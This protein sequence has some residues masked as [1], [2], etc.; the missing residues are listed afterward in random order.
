MKRGA[1]PLTKWLPG[2]RDVPPSL[3]AKG[4]LEP[5]QA[6][7][8]HGLLNLPIMSLFCSV[9]CPGSVIL[10]TYEAMQ[11]LKLQDR[12]IAGGFHSPME[13][14]CLDILLRGRTKLILCPARGL[15]RFRLRPEWKIPMSENRL[16]VLSPFDESVRRS[17]VHQ[18]SARNKFVAA[19]ADMTLIPFAARRSRTERFAAELLGSGKLVYTF[20]DAES[21]PLIDL[22]AR[23][24]PL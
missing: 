14:T 9:K 2:D 5:L 1:F 12:V 16:L 11:Q 23:V 19:L 13:R 22:G 24:I 15:R 3:A 10:K 7:G 21:Q 6:I 8:E 20:P 4:I 17:T 18:A